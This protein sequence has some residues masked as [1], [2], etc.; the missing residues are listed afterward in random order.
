MCEHVSACLFSLEVDKVCWYNFKNKF[1]QNLIISQR[2][3]NQKQEYFRNSSHA[4]PSSSYRAVVSPSLV[5]EY[6]LQEPFFSSHTK[7]INLKLLC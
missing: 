5:N 3:K 6:R 4:P 7:G 1:K 2:K